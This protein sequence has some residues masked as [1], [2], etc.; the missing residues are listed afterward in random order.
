MNGV[1]ATKNISLVLVSSLLVFA[2]WNC[3]DTLREEA[4]HPGAQH[5]HAGGH[6]TSGGGGSRF[7]WWHSSYYYAGGGSSVGGSSGGG[8]GGKGAVPSA[9]GRGGFGTS[10]HAAGG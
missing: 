8:G 3:G 9:S 5:G 7:F 10:G 6:H 2:G 4:E 1:R